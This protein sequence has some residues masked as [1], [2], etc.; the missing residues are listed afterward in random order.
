MEAYVRTNAQSMAVELKQ[1][2]IPD[3]AEREVR[4]KMKAFGVGI[5]DRYFIPSDARFPYF[6]G[7]EGSGVIEK[8]SKGVKGF[9]EGDQVIL[10]SSSLSKGGSWAEYTVVPSDMLIY[11]PESMSFEEGATIS[12][13][14]KTAMEC[15]NALNLKKADTLFIAGA[16]GAIGTFIIQLAADMGVRVIA[17]A[18]QKNHDYMKALGADITVDYKDAHWKDEVLKA[19]PNGVDM[20]LAIQ[21]NT[22]KDSM[23]VVKD[24]GKVITVSGDF[25]STERGI[26]VSQFEHL[27]SW[28]DALNGLVDKIVAGKVKVVIEKVYPFEQALDA[29]EKTESRHA[30]GK[31]VVSL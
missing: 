28:Q 2:A 20:A 19:I 24:N 15:M 4:V 8:I 5:H 23:D 29:L 6:I 14:G 16:S 11:L 25:I 18:S 1:V 26:S 3:V 30:R 10:N 21:P 27:L 9:V 22:A 7:L 12:V 17:L 13:A 31:T